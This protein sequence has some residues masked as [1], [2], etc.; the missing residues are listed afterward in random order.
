MKKLVKFVLIVGALAV[1][2]KFVVSKESKWQGLTESQVRDKLES[3]L[4]KRVPDEKRSAF[5]DKVVSKMRERGDLREDEEA[6]AATAEDADSDE[7][8]QDSSDIS[9]SV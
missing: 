7:A 5:T 8:R 3:R 1:L 4:P 6:S 2:I 9:A